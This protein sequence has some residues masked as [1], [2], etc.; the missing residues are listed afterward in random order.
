MREGGRET[1]RGSRHRQW[2]HASSNDGLEPVI[3]LV[4]DN[5]GGG[6]RETKKDWERQRDVH[7]AG[8]RGEMERVSWRAREISLTDQTTDIFLKKNYNN[9]RLVN[10]GQFSRLC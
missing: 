7:L 4:G 2:I 1:K 9:S 5:S 3:D 6:G 10:C 8:D